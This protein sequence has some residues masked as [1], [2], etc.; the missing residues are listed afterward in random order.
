MKVYYFNIEA[1][2]DKALFDEQMSLVDYT[3]KSRI[4]KMN[5]TADK[6][7]CLGAGILINFIKKHYDIDSLVENDKHGKPFFANSNVKF[8]I[9]HSGKYVVI[10][11]SDFDI[12]IDIQK[13]KA[14]KH[15]IAEKSF[16]KNESA[17]INEVP[18]ADTKLQRFC[19]VWTMKEA[20]LKHIGLGL[21][22]PLNSFE[23]DFDEVTPSIKGDVGKKFIQFKMDEKY[24]VSIC[25]SVEDTQ[26][27]IM[28]VELKE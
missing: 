22:K 27:D 23:I 7:R 28:E 1:L 3:R 6:L 14:D 17:Y 8:N 19:E 26:F 25:V 11:V 21:R 13:M 12:G 5:A 15:R 4:E 10:A 2:R 9:S 24:I 20:Y 16:L 18:N